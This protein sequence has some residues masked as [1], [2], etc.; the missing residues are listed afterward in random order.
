MENFDGMS[1]LVYMG[2][3]IIF[4][5]VFLNGTLIEKIF[6]VALLILVL[7]F[8]AAIAGSFIG[9][10]YSRDYMDI[11]SSNG[12]SHYMAVL[13]NQIILLLFLGM[14]VNIQDKVKKIFADNYIILSLLIP[15]ITMFICATVLQIAESGKNY[16]INVP[17]IVVSLVIINVITIAL[18]MIEQKMCQK[19]A[20]DSIRMEIYQ[21]QKRDVE[22]I[23]RAYNESEK[24]RHEINRVME[25]TQ[26]LIEKGQLERAYN[27]IR[28]FRKCEEEHSNQILYT[29]NIIMNHVLNRKIE[30]CKRKYITI[31]CFVCGKFD[32]IV[33][34]DLHILLENLID[35][36]I[37]ATGKVLNKKISIDIYGDDGGIGIEISNSTVDKAIEKNPEFKTTKKNKNGHGYGVQN[38]MNI[39]NIYNGS[40]SYNHIINNMVTCKV[41]LV[42]N[43]SEIEYNSRQ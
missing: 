1:I 35:N 20:D 13:T 3:F 38:V 16:I 5:I 11:I 19:Q 42:K 15:V 4:S 12:I 10:V 21:Y 6:Y 27:Y 31:K 24:T 39:V 23:R 9:L 28:D 32:G 30:E 40:I 2:A 36:T 17:I 18:L 8:S 22:E 37:E 33:D 25:M 7:S 26:H 43:S 41:V 14:I 34:L 29:D